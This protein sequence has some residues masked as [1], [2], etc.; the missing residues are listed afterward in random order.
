[1]EPALA[2]Y[3]RWLATDRAPNTV[4]AYRRDLAAYQTYL[5]TAGVAAAQVT[6]AEVDAYVASLRDIR[7]PASVARAT[8]AIR[9]FHRFLLD[10]GLAVGDPTGALVIGRVPAGEPAV[11]SEVQAAAV[12]EAV[13]G[14]DALGRRDRAVLELLYGTG[15]RTS[16]LVAL[17]VRDIGRE[18]RPS[19]RI[20]AGG[21]RGRVLPLGRGAATAVAAWLAPAGRAALLPTRARGTDAAALFLNARGGRISR[22][23]VWATLRRHGSGVGL[24]GALTPNLLRHSCAAH[25]VARG[26]SPAAVDALLGHPTWSYD[27]GAAYLA[28]HPRA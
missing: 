13:A 6:E 21:R 25:L 15:M 27:M 12:I 26:M 22:Q 19:V 2:A 24:G 1:V 23:G 11:L 17:D 4:A 9:S 7:A 28:A 16:E 3:L 8:V 10:A 14:D 18:D 5:A 20:A